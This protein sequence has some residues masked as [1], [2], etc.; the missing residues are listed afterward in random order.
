MLNGKDPNVF[1]K[2]KKD[3]RDPDRENPTDLDN[4]MISHINK[5]DTNRSKDHTEAATQFGKD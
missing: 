2:V 3:L 4:G 5:V 1:E